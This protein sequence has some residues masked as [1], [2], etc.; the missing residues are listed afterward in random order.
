MLVSD[1]MIFNLIKDFDEV[2]QS[3]EISLNQYRKLAKEDNVCYQ[4]DVPGF[5]KETL[6]VE[7][8]SDSFTVF[9][10]QNNKKARCFLLDKEDCGKEPVSSSVKDGVLEIS[11]KRNSSTKKKL[12]LT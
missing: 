2:F 6:E 12:I 7:L 4:V 9:Y 11:F 8:N 10:K 1:K 3:R 5:S